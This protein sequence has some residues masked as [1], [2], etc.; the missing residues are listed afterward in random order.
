MKWMCLLVGLLLLAGMPG[1]A[2]LYASSKMGDVAAVR[3]FLKST[4]DAVNLPVS[5]GFTPLE[6]AVAQGHTEVVAALLDAG[7]K[8]AQRNEIP[9]PLHL[10][11]WRG[12]MPIATM[13]LDRG[14]PVDALGRH[15]ETALHV[16]A[17]Q[18][19]LPLVHLLLA[20]GANPNACDMQ[21]WTPLHY[22]AWAGRLDVV[23]ALLQKGVD[24][25]RRSQDGWTP[26]YLAV[27]EGH[28]DVV[29]A[30][31]AQK[32]E[33]TKPDTQGTTPLMCALGSPVLS[34]TEWWASLYL[35]ALGLDREDYLTHK[36]PAY[37]RDA[38][39]L[40]KRTG[41]E[42]ARQKIAA[43]LFDLQRKDNPDI[44]ATSGLLT[45]A[46]ANGN[47]EILTFLLDR[48]AKPNDA[49]GN[50][51]PPLLAAAAN[52]QVAALDLLLKAGADLNAIDKNTSMNALLLAAQNGQTAMI[53]RL[54]DAGM[55]ID[56]PGG[57]PKQSGLWWAVS[58]KQVPAAL[59]LIA[60]GANV[61]TPWDNSFGGEPVAVYALRCQ[62][63][64]L[65]DKLLAAGMNLSVSNTY[66]NTLLHTAVS[67][68]NM[69]AVT[70]LLAH[71]V[72][73][74]EEL[75]TGA[76]PIF[77]AR[78]PQMADLLLAK[79]A[80][81]TNA[82]R[83][84][85]MAQYVDT[86]PMLQWCT[87][88]GMTFN[89]DDGGAAL[90][91][92]AGI[93]YLQ[94]PKTDVTD[95]MTFLVQQ[96]AN[97]NWRNTSGKTP[98]MAAAQTGL[99][100]AVTLLLEKG[101]D[102]NI[103]DNQGGTALVY[104]LMTDKGTEKAKMM[105]A[106]GAKPEG[107]NAKGETPLYLA[108]QKGTAE[109]VSL[110]LEKRPNQALATKEG[111]TPLMLAIRTDKPALV[112]LL[113]A[114]KPHLKS[115]KS[116]DG[117]TPVTLALNRGYGDAL[118][119]MLALGAEVNGMYKDTHNM[120]TTPLHTAAERWDGTIMTEKEQSSGSSVPWTTMDTPMMQPR[121]K[122]DP[123]KATGKQVVEAMVK[124]GAD[125]N[126][127]NTYNETPLYNAIRFRNMGTAV[128]LIEHGADLTVQSKRVDTPTVLHAAIYSNMV[129]L[130]KLLQAK[131]LKLDDACFFSA[132]HEEVMDYLVA[133]KLSPNVKSARGS[134][135][136]HNAIWAMSAT[137]ME[138][139]LV[140]GADPKAVDGAGRTTLQYMQD[141]QHDGSLIRDYAR[142]YQLLYVAQGDYTL[143]T[144]NGWTLL[145][146]AAE[147]NQRYVIDKLLANGVDIN[148]GTEPFGLTPLFAAVNA[149]NADAVAYLLTKKNINVNAKVQTGQT[150]LHAAIAMV[151]PPDNR[152][153]PPVM[154]PMAKE[155]NNP[156]AI[157]QLITLLL[158]AGADPTIADQQGKRPVDYVDAKNTDCWP[159][160]IMLAKVGKKPG[161]TTPGGLTLL[162]MTVAMGD[163]QNALPLIKAKTDLNTAD[164]QGRTPLHVA[165]ICRQYAL[166]QQLIDAGGNVTLADNAGMTPLHLLLD[167][168]IRAEGLPKAAVWGLSQP[169]TLTAI[170]SLL[171]HGAD[172]NARTKSGKTAL[173]LIPAVPELKPLRDKLLA[174]GAKE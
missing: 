17:W 110:L 64:N 54:L 42:A 37:E 71:G 43:L 143:K 51:R 157:T 4:P 76:V 13:L 111:D 173:T 44:T 138:Q 116:L 46:A 164:S 137:T 38:T 12:S 98:L 131:G 133:Q 122:P 53:T 140:H 100:E 39:L 19:I 32:A 124:A 144:A 154:D 163:T 130:V 28:A 52:G 160:I 78:S 147:S 69:P 156:A 165:T 128:Y 101:A 77:Y 150:P 22:A 132:R 92:F 97:P 67:E 18:G 149:R 68:D 166:V 94:R 79:G 146:A 108:V 48:G 135:P 102:P 15:Q 174:K 11:A 62:D 96:G 21:Y 6:I 167:M 125:V 40:P 161:Y 61:N 170:D 35:Q 84:H 155:R 56:T 87:A 171:A 65:L 20:R 90:Y 172:I 36:I 115:V 93:V 82:T 3:G 105:L 75:K 148:I 106:K 8:G 41:I 152:P 107:T 27:A 136:L 45:A 139:L 162:H 81:L 1:R 121:P 25:N 113:L 58:K 103:A 109:L 83:T 57:Y 86:L 126:A 70:W 31:L 129:E 63:A 9:F 47:V 95:V 104:A 80:T 158:A 91:K 26:L 49:P 119:Q 88:H 50:T 7:A 89:G 60:R 55:A 85:S 66:G 145:H 34:F 112:E 33:Y 114:A 74:N 99:P 120:Q 141:M 127:V 118:V 142:K 24:V 30:L 23:Q 2:D 134:T 29:K 16:A 72:N 169:E 73:V 168:S 159:L 123:A 153:A 5:R 10:A 151:R 14:V 59:A 117:A